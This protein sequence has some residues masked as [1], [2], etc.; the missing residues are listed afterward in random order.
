MSLSNGN[1]SLF[2][3]ALQIKLCGVTLHCDWGWLQISDS[4]A[5]DVLRFLGPML[6]LGW[7]VCVLVYVPLTVRLT[8]PCYKDRLCQVS[9][10]PNILKQLT[11]GMMMMASDQQSLH[12]PFCTMSLLHSWSIHY[13]LLAFPPFMFLYNFF[14]LKNNGSTCWVLTTK[15]PLYLDLLTRHYLH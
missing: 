9:S 7:L 4:K 2:C 11:N 8:P 5:T 10:L 6:L 13:G 12:I 15:Y 14:S 1:C 3:F